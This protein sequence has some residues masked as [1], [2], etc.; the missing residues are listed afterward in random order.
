LLKLGLECAEHLGETA[1]LDKWLRQASTLK[2]GTTDDRA[3]LWCGEALRLMTLGQLD[4]AQSLLEKA[5]S[6]F[7]EAKD[8]R[9]VAVTMGYIADILFRR[10]NLDEALRIRQAEEL[11]VYDRLDDA[12]E[13]A[14]TMGKIADIF[15]AK[16]ELDEALRIH[17]FEHRPLVEQLGM[18]DGRLYIL[19]KT[20]GI[21]VKKGIGDR[22]TFQRVLSDLSQAYKLAKQLTHFEFIC[23][24]ARDLGTLLA[25]AGAKG[26]A[27]PLLAEGRAGYVKLGRMQ[28]VAQIDALLA[29]LDAPPAPEG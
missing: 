8:E 21:R 19:L 10:G 18:L 29:Q 9:H 2:G 26:Q 25:M 11:P 16:G 20:S 7:I 3:K 17:E 13:R 5:K 4:E 24:A 6:A 12:R 27:R 1:L 14:V 23:L 28:D 22:E 15:E